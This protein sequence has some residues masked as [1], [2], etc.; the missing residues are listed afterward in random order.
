MLNNNQSNDM[1]Q[2]IL[3]NLNESN[4]VMFPIGLVEYLTQ[5]YGSKRNASKFSRARAFYDLLDRYLQANAQGDIIAVSYTELSKLW[6]WSRPSVIAFMEKLSKMKVI[7]IE[8]VVN[9]N[10]VTLR[11]QIFASAY[12]HKLI[13]ESFGLGSS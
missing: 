11:P 8:K 5:D 2:K 1:L 7:T 12:F 10:R 9:Y 4:M 3:D 6:S 13:D